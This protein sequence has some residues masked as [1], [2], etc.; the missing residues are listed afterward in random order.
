MHVKGSQTQ[1]SDAILLPPGTWTISYDLTLRPIKDDAGPCGTD[2]DHD[3]VPAERDNCARVK[4]ADQHDGDGDGVGDKCDPDIIHSTCKQRMHLMINAAAGSDAPKSTGCWSWNV[5]APRGGGVSA[6]HALEHWHWCGNDELATKRPL[7]PGYWV[8]DDVATG[9]FRDPVYYKSTAVHGIKD[10]A[11]RA[12]DG[13]AASRTHGWVFLAH[14]GPRGWGLPKPADLKQL[15]AD[16]RIGGK[17]IIDRF[18]VQVY[19]ATWG[20][21]GACPPDAGHLWR[22]QPNLTPALEYEVGRPHARVVS[23]ARA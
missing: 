10:C 14:R 13:G 7:Q 19:D 2:P 21:A 22:I 9:G 20:G 23:T 6:R 4:N 3:C 1:R 17:S 18:F 11:T 12:A 5:A 8:Y 15:R 16:T